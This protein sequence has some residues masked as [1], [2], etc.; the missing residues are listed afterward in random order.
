MRRRCSEKT[1]DAQ[2]AETC[3]VREKGYSQRRACRLVG[4]HSKTYRYVT[5]RSGDEELRRQLRE[6]ASHRRHTIW[7]SGSGPASARTSLYST[8]RFGQSKREISGIAHLSAREARASPWLSSGLKFT[9]PNP[10][11]HLARWGLPRCPSS[12]GYWVGNGTA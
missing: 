4:L 9:P 5:K 7:R 11:T 3:C 10:L 8:R 6:L 12:T 1:S 2:L